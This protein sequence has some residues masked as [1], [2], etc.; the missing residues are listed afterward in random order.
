VVAS[1]V[2]TLLYVFGGTF[3]GKP[4]EG[5]T[6]TVLA[7]TSKNAMPVDLIIATLS[8]EP[9]T[10]G[11][12]PTNEEMPL[13]IRLT[14][15]FH[16]AFPQGKPQPF[17]PRADQ[18]KGQD[19]KKKAE[20]KAEPQLKES[21]EENSVV[22]VADVD[23]LS[24]GAAVE[25]QEVFGQRVAVPRNGNLALALGLVEQLSGDSALISLRSRASFSKPLTVLREMEAQ[26][27]QQYLGKIKELEDS[28]NQTQENLQK[29][30]KSKAGVTSTILTA[31]QQ[32]ELDNFR[33]KAAEAR[34]ALKELRKRLR[35][36]TDTLEFWTK[37][38]N[39]GLV[40]LLV[41]LAGL[42]LALARRRKSNPA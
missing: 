4:A 16:T 1:Q 32:A 28:L 17:M 8:G 22:L 20:D 41:A 13:A 18:K 29:L 10:R 5:L 12:Q 26:A 40:P 21:K 2:G 38:V 24:D 19:E 36:E 33:K 37:V 9:S 6:Q 31:E 30:Q 35:V 3:K 42:A 23:L 15:K 34:L 7:R 11:F 14:G 39:I 27:Q 25:I